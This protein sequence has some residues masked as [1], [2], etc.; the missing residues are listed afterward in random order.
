MGVKTKP[1]LYSDQQIVEM[2]ARSREQAFRA[3]IG[4]YSPRL[5]AYVRRMLVSHDDT[6]DVLQ[7]T[8]IRA[9][10]NFEGLKQSAA[11]SSWLYR[12]ATNRTMTFIAEKARRAQV[13]IDEMEIADDRE[14]DRAVAETDR[15]GRLTLKAL[16]TLP[17]VQQTVFSMKH[18]EG[19]KYREISQILGTSEGALKASYHLAV[20]KIRHY[21]AT[22]YEN[23]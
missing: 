3:L 14:I 11:L 8:F 10:E 22:H 12:I 4:K 16:H 20:E 19:L 13:P 17:K 23:E 5:Y 6:D 1:E 21:V 18:F 2:F 9:W 15:L 7:D